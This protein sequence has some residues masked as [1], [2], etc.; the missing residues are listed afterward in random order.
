MA[1]KVLLA[2]FKDIVR[3]AHPEKPRTVPDHG[4]KGDLL[5]VIAN[6]DQPN[7]IDEFKDASIRELY[8]AE[9]VR[10]LIRQAMAAKY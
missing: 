9:D 4:V 10:F 6:H 3:H 8:G 5:V 7:Q 2:K 1:I